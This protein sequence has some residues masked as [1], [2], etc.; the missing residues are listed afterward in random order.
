MR[1]ISIM[2]VTVLAS[3]AGVPAATL[4]L[5]QNDAAVDNPQID[6]T[7]VENNGT[8]TTFTT[9]PYDTANTLFY[10]NNAS[11]S[12]IGNVG[13]RFEFITNTFRYPAANVV[14]HGLISGTTH[15]LV[16][17]TNITNSGTMAVGSGGLIRLAGK[18][19]DLTRGA[20]AVGGAAGGETFA[21]GPNTSTFYFND[22]GVTDVYWG[23]GDDND[24][25][26]NGQAMPLNSFFFPQF[27]LPFISSP[28]HEVV[29]QFGFT[30]TVVVPQSFFGRAYE[31]HVRVSTNFA[32]REVYQIVFVPA[33]TDTNLLT[34][35]RFTG[36]GFGAGAAVIQLSLPDVD[37]TTL[38]PFTNAIT[39]FDATAQLRTNTVIATNALEQTFRP[40]VHNVVRGRVFNFDF[41][42]VTNLAYDPSL[43]NS[44]AYVSN[45]VGVTYHG[46]SAN[47][48]GS[49]SFNF[50]SPSL[51]NPTNAPG[52]VEIS[53]E[54][55]DLSLARIRAETF[56]SIRA[57]NL[58]TLDAFTF[59]S[60]FVN[61]N[62]KTTNETLVVDA[63][64]G[65]T[66]KRL[67]G[68][69]FL[70]SGFWTN[71]FR[72]TP[73]NVVMREFAITILDHNLAATV[74]VSYG[75]VLIKGTN[76]VINDPVSP[77]NQ[78]QVDARTVTVGSN[79]VLNFPGNVGLAQFPSLQSLTNYG[80]INANFVQLGS[81]APLPL[82]NLVNRGVINGN[83]VSLRATTLESSGQIN[84]FNG[85]LFL[86]F[87]NGVFSNATITAGGNVE[88]YG[89]TLEIT[90]STIIPASALVL[91]ITN[92]LAD[93]GPTGSNLWN[94]TDG[95]RF[96]TRPASGDLL[97]TTIRS[98]APQFRA[99]PH[100]TAGTNRGATAAGFS[101]NTAIGR[102]VLDGSPSSLF[103]FSPLTAN[104]ALYVDFLEFQNSATN[105]LTSLQINSGV[106][107]YFA[108]SN[109]PA[110]KLDGAIGGRLRWVSSYAGA[111]SSITI[112]NS[113]GSVVTVNRAL[114]L[115]PTIDSDGDGIPNK[116]DGAPFDPPLMA[117]RVEAAASRD[118][119]PVNY[120]VI[121]WPAAA[122]TTYRIEFRA[123]VDGAW[124][125][126]M[127]YTHGPETSTATVYDPIVEGTCFYRVSYRY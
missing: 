63:L 89:S 60:P 35:V 110:E 7:A 59:D 74:P 98:F 33:A 44:N 125:H 109:L 11:G 105:Y 61:Y 42:A 101:N 15:V 27:N 75:E 40:R 90:H 21:F 19:V 92:R 84:C 55:L 39:I 37:V 16:N 78:F 22:P 77:V 54:Q 26:G 8:I 117:M 126:L 97:G 70:W 80:T 48:A 96:N 68:D 127:D 23:S 32:G 86:R 41:L 87:V 52:R 82:L 124:Q 103:V 58:I 50:S 10:T 83:S 53:A 122:N 30:N 79:G 123:T 25:S 9:L 104:S 5:Y 34:D 102:L 31:A 47:V 113:D 4:P 6:A 51:A 99:V 91:N 64:V 3:M 72:L 56:V 76:V 45:S 111:N 106:T 62:L 28:F 114:R 49:S 94:L 57:T 100:L 46:Y 115:S 20:L 107:V 112:T 116:F 121:S 95:I 29:D 118:T 73:S 66:V 88:L 120:A 93:G 71:A 14:N 18:S 43:I 119:D 81:D 69:I 36:G 65:Q 2:V 13:F 17:A 85:P 24:L 108:D 1:F 67:S 38:Q 12:M